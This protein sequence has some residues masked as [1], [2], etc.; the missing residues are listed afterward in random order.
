MNCPPSLRLLLKSLN[1]QYLLRWATLQRT[2][3]GFQPMFSVF[4]GSAREEPALSTRSSSLRSV[5]HQHYDTNMTPPNTNISVLLTNVNVAPAVQLCGDLLCR[6]CQTGNALTLIPDTLTNAS[7]VTLHAFYVPRFVREFQIDY[8]ANYPCI[9]SL[10]SAGPGDIL[11]GWT[12][13]QTNDGAGSGSY[14]LTMASPNTNDPSTSLPY[15]IMGDL[16][17]FQFEYQALPSCQPGFRLFHCG[18]RTFYS[19]RIPPGG[20]CFTLTN[21]N[22]FVT[23]YPP[24]PPLGTP[25]PWLETYFPGNTNFAALELTNVNGNGLPVWQDYIA[26]L[27]P[28]N[29]NSFFFVYPI[30]PPQVGAPVIT[31]PTAQGRVYR[32][33]TA[34]TPGAWMTL[35]DNIMGTGSNVSITDKR[36]LSGVGSIYYRVV[37][38]YSY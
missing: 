17:S 14:W 23:N 10:L 7:M 18:S 30:V 28:T 37:V 1:S 34:I 2:G 22:A 29:T 38:S 21:T 27:N 24:T 19:N 4:V 13:S 35:L 16:L 20:Q 3:I 33:D 15:G 12:L 8:R 32:V 25:V 26:G 5:H 31:F 9:P 36:N 11:N 6:G